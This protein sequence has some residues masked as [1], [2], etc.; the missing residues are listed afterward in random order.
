MSA[1][2]PAK[3]R[4]SARLLPGQKFTAPETKLRRC[5]VCGVH[6]TNS[7][8]GGYNGRSALAGDLFCL[9]CADGKGGGA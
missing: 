8:L 2:P 6:V 4:A 1:R 5:V 9:S 7:N 3:D